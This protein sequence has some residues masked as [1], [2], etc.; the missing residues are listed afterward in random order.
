[1]GGGIFSFLAQ[2]RQLPSAQFDE[3]FATPR[4]HDL[5]ELARA[6]GHHGETATNATELRAALDDGLRR[7][8]LSVV[9]A[10]VPE[11]AHNVVRHEELNALVARWWSRR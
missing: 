5:A 1:A 10:R 4:R 8:G 6:F 2:A 11:R 9:V 7:R 3:L